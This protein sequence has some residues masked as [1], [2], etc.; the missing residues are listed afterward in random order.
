MDRKRELLE[1]IKPF[2]IL[3]VA[4]VSKENFTK[5]LF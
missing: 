2:C 1:K 5:R 4:V 3:N